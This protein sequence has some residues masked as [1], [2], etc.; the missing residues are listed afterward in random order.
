MTYLWKYGDSLWNILRLNKSFTMWS[1]TTAILMN[2]PMIFFDLCVNLRA[3]APLFSWIWQYPPEPREPRS[4]R[5]REA[6]LPRTRA[7]RTTLLGQPLRVPLLPPR[8]RCS[9]LLVQPGGA[10]RA[11]GHP[12]AHRNLLSTLRNGAGFVSPRHPTQCSLPHAAVS[13]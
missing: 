9:L 4:Q 13:Q 2:D 10:Q 1:R 8:C 5:G 7:L 3:I 12:P 6:S 11:L